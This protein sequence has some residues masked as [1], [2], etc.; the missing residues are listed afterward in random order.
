[1]TAIPTTPCKRC[2]AYIFLTGHFNAAG[3]STCG[4]FVPGEGAVCYPC[5]DAAR[6][7]IE[8]EQQP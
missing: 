4:A 2:G 1:M 5:L 6:E 8:R 3:R 7:P